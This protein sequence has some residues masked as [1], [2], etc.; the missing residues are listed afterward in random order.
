MEFSNREIAS[1]IWLGAILGWAATKAPVRKSFGGLA[2]AFCQPAILGTLALSAGY[3]VLIVVAL[4]HVG[5]WTWGNLK[6]TALWSISFAFAALLDINRASEDRTF[7]AKAIREALAIT[8]ALTFVVEFYS[9][10]LLV[11]LVAVPIITVLGLM[12]IMA[13]SN[14]DHRAA[15]RFLSGLL[16]IIGLGYLGYSFYRTF[17]DAEDFAKLKTLR[18]FGIPILLTLAFLPFLYLVVLYSVYERVFTLLPWSIPDEHLRARAKW[19]SF[20][21]FGW[22]IGG[23]Q[24]WKQSN[25]RF[26]ATDE[27]S[28]RQSFAEIKMLAKREA[29]PPAVPHEDGWSPYAAKDFL[30]DAGLPTRY[31]HRSFEDEWFASSSYLEVG[32]GGLPNNLAYYV[33]G[34]EFA[35]TELKLK[36]NVNQPSSPEEAEERFMRIGQALLIAALGQPAATTFFG[37][38]SRLKSFQVG[39]GRQGVSLAL[40]R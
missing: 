21:T 39:D 7:F 30:E 19:Q 34:T 27:E 2:R 28:L 40:D 3:I 29:N 14:A 23:L 1:Y 31:Y 22:D 24:R 18:E 38:L 32:Q 9:F 17:H 35:A 20:C 15:E 25:A 5:I 26:D 33:N 36:L 11:E 10:S 13:A 37:K 6:T 12:K 16:T 4:E 8:G